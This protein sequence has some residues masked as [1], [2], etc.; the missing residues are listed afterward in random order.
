MHE[1]RERAAMRVKKIF[2]LTRGRSLFGI[3]D[4]LE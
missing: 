2:D 4:R 3:E 1:R